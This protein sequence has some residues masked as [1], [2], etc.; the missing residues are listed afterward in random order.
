M[1]GLGKGYTSSWILL[2]L[3]TLQQSPWI[4]HS[5][6]QGKKIHCANFHLYV[7]AA[8]IDRLGCS[9]LLQVGLIVPT[10]K[11]CFSNSCH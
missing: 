3:R 9:F 2:L 11:L 6:H 8:V 7:Q 10:L 4:S 1:L 5:E